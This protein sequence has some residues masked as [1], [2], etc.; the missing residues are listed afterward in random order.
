M[1][2]FPELDEAEDLLGLLILADIGVPWGRT[3]SKNGQSRRCV[4]RMPSCGIE[5]FPLSANQLFENAGCHRLIN[6]GQSDL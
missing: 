5:V 2:T 4:G 6:L 3:A 1:P